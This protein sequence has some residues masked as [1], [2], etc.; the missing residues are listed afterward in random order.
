ML[1]GRFR[2]KQDSFA[3]EIFACIDQLS[4]AGRSSAICQ[5]KD[6]DTSYTAYIW[7]SGLVPEPGRWCNCKSS[8]RQQENKNFTEQ[9]YSFISSKLKI[10]WF[11]FGGLGPARH[12]KNIRAEHPTLLK[13]SLAG[14]HELVW[15]VNKKRRGNFTSRGI[16]SQIISFGSAIRPQHRS[17][18]AAACFAPGVDKQ[19]QP[20]L[21]WLLSKNPHFTCG[22]EHP[23]A[24]ADKC[25]WNFYHRLRNL[26]PEVSQGSCDWS[27]TLCSCFGL[28]N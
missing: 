24:W 11:V 25:V 22:V 27:P 1:T 23:D 19:S 16:N 14:I 9:F 6:V 21:N 18:P 4:Q 2:A 12:C 8:P 7:C 28:P 3:A 20:Y 10:S 15:N 13:P 5:M 26:S 17:K